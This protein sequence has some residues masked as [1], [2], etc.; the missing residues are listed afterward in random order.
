[1]A[2]CSKGSVVCLKDKRGYGYE[3]RIKRCVSGWLQ[4][5]LESCA[6]V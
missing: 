2:V 6:Y 1:V 5:I 4:G 3:T